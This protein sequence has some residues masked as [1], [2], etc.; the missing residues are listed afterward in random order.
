MQ[1]VA[2]QFSHTTEDL[3]SLL[4]S[5]PPYRMHTTDVASCSC[6]HPRFQNRLSEIRLKCR[7]VFLKTVVNVS[8]FL[9][10][11]CHETLSNKV[12]LQEGQSADKSNRDC[13]KKDCECS[14]HLRALLCP[15]RTKLY[16]F[17]SLFILT[18]LC[19]SFLLAS[20]PRH[21]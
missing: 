6:S 11:P 14:S 17:F 3:S 20:I 13:S 7:S 21:I 5:F 19:C 15:I 8:I 9:R 10:L 4:S 1:L 16:L 2:L 18:G 12:G